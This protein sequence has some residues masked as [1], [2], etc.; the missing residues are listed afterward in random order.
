MSLVA[1]VQYEKSTNSCC[2][3]PKNMTSYCTIRKKIM[4]GHMSYMKVFHWVKIIPV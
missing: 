3:I 4:N 1:T 2:A